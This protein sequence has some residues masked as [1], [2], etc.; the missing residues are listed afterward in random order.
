MDNSGI[1]FEATIGG[2]AVDGI[3]GVVTDGLRAVANDA[4]DL[5][6]DAQA[7]VGTARAEVS[8]LERELANARADA[9]REVD[10]IKADLDDAEGVV[11]GIASSKSY[12]H[13][14]R[15]SRYRAW[16]SAVSATK[17]APWWKKPY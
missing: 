13:K 15:Q 6:D 10:K 7:K 11:N 8:R 1:R 2:R 3:K 17:R 12:W 16:R 9:Q 5:I 14:Q 4:Q